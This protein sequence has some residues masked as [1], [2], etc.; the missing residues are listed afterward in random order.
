MEHLSDTKYL[1]KECS[2]GAKMAI[3][4]I[5]DVIDYTQDTHLKDILENSRKEHDILEHKLKASIT[6]YHV[7]DKD[8]NIMA[9]GLSK[10]K[11]NMKLAMNNGKDD[12]TIADLITDGCNMGIKSLRRYLNQ[13]PTAD[14]SIKE[15]AYELIGLEEDL[16]GEMAAYL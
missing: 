12:A 1:L 3:E 15:M 16:A 7:E 10:M 13:Y 4:S 5:D 11:I 2:A 14:K 8:P 9:Q 6:A